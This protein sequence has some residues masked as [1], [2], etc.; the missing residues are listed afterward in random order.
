MR[1]GNKDFIA[2]FFNQV[3]KSGA[4]QL[5]CSSSPAADHQAKGET[6]NSLFSSQGSGGLFT[7]DL[8]KAFETGGVHTSYS[9]KPV[10][11]AGKYFIAKF[12]DSSAAAGTVG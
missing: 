2:F 3:S 11:A 8:L 6:V 7:N 10:P 1:E 12:R 5:T 4:P 9:I